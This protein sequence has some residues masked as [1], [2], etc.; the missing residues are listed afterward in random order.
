MDGS[1][2]ILEGDDSF[3]IDGEK[4]PSLH[5]TGLEDYFNGAWYYYGLFDLPLHGLLEKA[6]M[7]TC[8]YR[9]H[10]EAPI[11]F[12]KSLNVSFEFGDANRTRGYISAVA[13]WY[14]TEPVAAGTVIPPLPERYPK[15]NKVE[16][17]AVMSNLFELERAGLYRD[18]INRCLYYAERFKGTQLPEI[19]KLRALRYEEETTGFDAVKEKYKSFAA[20]AKSPDIRRQAEQ[21]LWFHQSEDNVLLGTHDN[22][23][24]RIYVDGRP[25]GAV[26]NVAVLSVW[27]LKLKPGRHCIAVEATPVRKDAWVSVYVRMHGTNLVSGAD[28]ECSKAKPSSWPNIMSDTSVDWVP[29]VRG[30]MMLPKMNFW[31]FAP[32]SFISMQSGRQLMRPWKGWDNPPK[33]AYLRKVFTIK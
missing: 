12:D 29:V 18:A 32:N 9:F 15:P 23:N 24:C 28:W 22:A 21:L 26:N 2:N 10:L 11:R 14:Q 30:E 6:A 8:Q 33:T 1:W 16:F 20:N 13:Y 4:V 17:V 31:Q 3:F 19:M 5:G 7:N 27:P 25:V